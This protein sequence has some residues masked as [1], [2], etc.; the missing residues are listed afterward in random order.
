VKNSSHESSPERSA[1]KPVKNYRT[2]QTQQATTQRDKINRTTEDENVYVNNNYKSKSNYIKVI[3]SESEDDL[4]TNEYKQSDTQ[5]TVK[6]IRDLKNKSIQEKFIIEE[7]VSTTTEQVDNVKITNERSVEGNRT[8]RE[9]SPSKVI[10]KEN[11]LNQEK[12][13]ENEQFSS[14]VK[15]EKKVN[16]AATTSK[17]KSPAKEV[18][19]SVEK[20]AATHP[21]AESPEKI[22]QSPNSKTD[23]AT[24]KTTSA[25]PSSIK[26]TVPSSLEKTPSK[27]SLLHKDSKENVAHKTVKKDLS[28][29]KVD[30]KITRND[31]KTLVHKNSKESV[32]PKTLVKKSSQELLK[33]KK[34]V[35][36]YKKSQLNSPETKPKTQDLK[37]KVIERKDS[38]N[39]FKSSVSPQS[40]QSKF[41]V[42][43]PSGETKTTT[44]SKKTIGGTNLKKIPSTTGVTKP[45]TFTSTKP[46]VNET[47]LKGTKAYSKPTTSFTAKS[48]SKKTVPSS[49]NKTVKVEATTKH[50]ELKSKEL[51]DELPPDNF[52]SDTDLDDTTE[53]QAYVKRR[54]SS[55]CSS[56]SSPSPSPSES[57]PEDEEGKRKIKELDNIRIEAEEE[58]GKKMTNNDA[59]LNVVVQLPQSSRESSPEYSSK[60]GKPY[61]SVSDDASLPRYADV[62]S[63]P[64]DVNDYR[65][66]GN[67]YDV[68]T[69]L[70]EDSKTTVA[71]RM[72]KFLYNANRQEELKTTEIPQSPQAV[73]KAKQIFESIAKGRIEETVTNNGEIDNVDDGADE[74]KIIKTIGGIR[75]SPKNVVAQ[76]S[77]LTRKISGASDY[78]TRKEFFENR[79]SNVTSEKVKHSTP[80]NVTRS[81][82]IKERRASF[83]TNVEKKTPLA[84]KTNVP[85]TRSPDSKN[86]SPDR[87]TKSPA[88][89]SKTEVFN[90]KVEETNK[91]RRLSGSTTV[92]DR[93]ATFEKNEKKDNRTKHGQPV[94]SATTHTG[95][96]SDTYTKSVAA[97]NARLSDRAPANGITSPIRTNKNPERTTTVSSSADKTVESAGRKTPSKSPD[98]K[99]TP[100]EKTTA[101]SP[102]RIAATA[103]DDDT[104]VNRRG[105]D[106]W[107][108]QRITTTTVKADIG[109]TAKSPSATKTTPTTIRSTSVNNADD[110]VQIEEIFDLHVLELMVTM[111]NAYIN[112]KIRSS[113]TSNASCV[114]TIIQTITFHASISK[115]CEI[116]LKE[117]ET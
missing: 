73:R 103:K 114:R 108:R 53:T 65:L 81:S 80:G 11:K 15:A 91:A 78:K 59:L 42:L 35:T 83:E 88:K 50:V 37:N 43:K 117:R 16:D 39:K 60:Y 27:K 112:R 48:Q 74:P 10:E 89:V 17:E 58:Y 84:D 76:P 3:K 102:E 77:V 22:L 70:D 25:I 105:N 38:A 94:L 57:S 6:N 51:E 110:E 71:D 90:V 5:D 100:G 44:D 56:S 14:A 113:R 61:C 23:K 13:I 85:R 75:D 93:T 95:R 66:P 87:T 109:A 21:S 64:E 29:E 4:N 69:D 67:R 45:K 19:K 116:N 79:K 54:S 33:D 41:R 32:T 9:K 111:C 86:S 40:S 98:R 47:P 34:L 20:D 46:N 72:S 30:V 92:K 49:F 55:S 24:K 18:R 97:S 7:Q 106:T 2:S 96:V 31:S 62:V 52:E 36:T 82:S 115:T 12:F 28:R 99:V 1:F 63:E 107:S 8:N 26:K 68:V 101:K 104:V